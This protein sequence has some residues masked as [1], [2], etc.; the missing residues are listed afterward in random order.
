MPPKTSIVLFIVSMIILVIVQGHLLPRT[1]F[2]ILFL[3]WG[4]LIAL[5]GYA[6]QISFTNSNRII[7]Y[8]ILVQASALFY[9][10]NL[11]DDVYRFL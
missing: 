9:I 11:S 10:P 4:A 5:W 6:G 7:L 1:D 3:L 2:H 8:S